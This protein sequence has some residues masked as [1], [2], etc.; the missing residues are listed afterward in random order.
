MMEWVETFRTTTLS[1]PDMVVLVPSSD[2]NPETEK[3]YGEEG[4]DEF[5]D[6]NLM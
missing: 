5:A 3:F 1:H 4:I 6:S 2:L